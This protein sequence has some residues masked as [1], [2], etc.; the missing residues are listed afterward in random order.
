MH[1]TK[2]SIRFFRLLLKNLKL[3]V[4]ASGPLSLS[5]SDRKERNCGREICLCLIGR[6]VW[7]T[8]IY[9]NDM[10]TDLKGADPWIVV[11]RFGT[12]ILS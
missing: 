2:A 9:L 4:S 7:W 6:K 12:D 8:Y 11:A 3:G 1:D 10:E 5:D